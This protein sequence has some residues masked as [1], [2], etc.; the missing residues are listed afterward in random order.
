M[1]RDVRGPEWTVLK[2]TSFLIIFVLGISLTAP[3]ALSVWETA[4]A[5]GFSG[6]G[7][8]KADCENVTI[9]ATQAEVTDTQSTLFDIEQFTEDA[10]IFA[11]TEPEDWPEEYIVIEYTLYS[12]GGQ[13]LDTGRTAASTGGETADVIEVDLEQKDAQIATEIEVVA[14]GATDDEFHT[15]IE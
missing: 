5:D 8:I 13:K 4:N 3:I 9:E 15:T 6:C 14:V 7:Q 1:A 2:A 11:V 12:E 10:L